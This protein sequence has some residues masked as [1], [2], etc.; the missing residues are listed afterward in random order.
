MPGSFA[1]KQIS[2]IYG[3]KLKFHNSWED[4]VSLFYSWLKKEEESVKTKEIPVGDVQAI[5]KAIK[6][7]EV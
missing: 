2:K 4:S 3:D 1:K 7:A 6:D 5:A